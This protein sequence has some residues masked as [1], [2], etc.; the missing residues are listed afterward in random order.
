[1]GFALLLQ[2]HHTLQTNLA[3]VTGSPILQLLRDQYL[4]V[5]ARQTIRQLV[6]TNYIVA[7]YFLTYQLG[8]IQHEVGLNSSFL[9]CT[10]FITYAGSV[11]RPCLDD[12]TPLS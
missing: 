12:P 8:I 3:D 10:C 1:V 2:L 9:N 4:S 7:I 5:A 6:M 11:H